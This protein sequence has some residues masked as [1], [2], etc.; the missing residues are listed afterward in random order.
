MIR[1]TAFLLTACL[2][3]SGL[4]TAQDGFAYDPKLAVTVTAA[5][6]QSVLVPGPKVQTNVDEF[7]RYD[8]SIV[9]NQ[10][11][12]DGRATVVHHLG[13]SPKYWNAAVFLVGANGHLS[14]LRDSVVRRVIW[15]EDSRYLT[16]HWG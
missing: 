1:P 16:R 11:S 3:L 2:G 5:N 10:S 13:S 4:C 6:G 9:A 12:P 7:F 8:H 15:S 14:E